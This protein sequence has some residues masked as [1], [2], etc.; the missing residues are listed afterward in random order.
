LFSTSPTDAQTGGLRGSL[1][2]WR[3]YSAFDHSARRIKGIL[4]M[5]AESV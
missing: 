1:S 5:T 4:S 3:W 2:T